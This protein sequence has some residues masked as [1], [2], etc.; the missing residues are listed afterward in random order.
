MST[1]YDL[2]VR[3]SGALCSIRVQNNVMVAMQ[4]RCK[5]RIYPSLITSLSDLIS[6]NK[7]ILVYMS[8]QN[9]KLK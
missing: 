4:M 9:T 1:V 2:S 6:K 5:I 8:E 7:G 3:I